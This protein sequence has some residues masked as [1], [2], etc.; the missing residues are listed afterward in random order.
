[1]HRQ[2]NHPLRYIIPDGQ[3]GLLIRHGRLAVERNRVM[4]G[5]G[6]AGFLQAL[7]QLVAVW[8]LDGVLRP[9]AG[10]VGFDM[11]GGVDA[12]LV[13]EFGV[14]CGDAVAG[15]ELVIEDLELGE[16]DGGL[17]GVQ[18]AVH[19]HADVVV[20]P[21]LPVAGNLADDLGQFFVVGEDGATIAVA[22][23]RLAGE[24]AGGADGGQVAALAAL[25]GG[26][27]ALRTVFD[28]GQPVAGGN[29]VDGVVV[30]ALPV[31]GYGD[32]GLGARGDGGLELCRI[33]VA[34]ARVDVYVHGAGAQHGGGFGRGDVGKAGGDDLIARAHAQRHEGD[35]QGVG[36]VGHADAVLRADVG[37][38]LFFQLGHFGAE[39]VAAVRQHAG[40]AGVD[41]ALDARLLGG[42]VDEFHQA[43]SFLSAVPSST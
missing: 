4:D 27:E 3:P 25:V 9:G 6:D 32:D 11:G 21:V 29:C 35:L 19:A 42:K 15:G 26:A 2:A 30:G 39:D 10:V 14:A 41:P 37:G 36:A 22:A 7:L 31:E 23:Q 1:M 13:E 17:E 12:G 5:G 18:A 8:H 16:Q 20:A 40:N 38:E 24:E 34:G 43:A 28:D 33:Q